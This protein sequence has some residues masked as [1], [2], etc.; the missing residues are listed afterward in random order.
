VTLCLG[1][2]TLATFAGFGTTLRSLGMPERAGWISA[3]SVALV[4]LAGAIGTAVVSRETAVAGFAFSACWAL[5]AIEA[6]TWVAPVRV[7]AL[8]ALVTVLAGLCTPS[9]AAERPRA[10]RLSRPPPGNPPL[11]APA[12]VG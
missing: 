12:S 9:G 8:L 7:A 4:L 3:L 6:E 11:D 5:A 2:A 1:C 10:V